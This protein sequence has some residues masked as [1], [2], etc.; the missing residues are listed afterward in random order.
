MHPGLRDY[1]LGSSNRAL[2]TF[3]TRGQVERRSRKAS[4]S[5]RRSRLMLGR[6]DQN[7][8]VALD[9]GYHGEAD[10]G[11]AGSRLYDHTAGLE[12]AAPLRIFDHGK[13]DP[14][15]D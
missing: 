3:L 10:A 5:R 11:I 2:H 9:R 15:L 7:E 12:P 6:D 8:L 14:I 1:F 13:R 4:I